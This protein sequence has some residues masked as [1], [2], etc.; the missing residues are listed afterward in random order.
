MKKGLSYWAF[1]NKTYREAFEYAKKNGFDGIEVT[2]N[3]S[4]EVTPETTDEEILEIK[5]QGLEAG[6]EFFSVA[7]GLLWDYPLTSNDPAV[8]EKAMNLVR[9]QL[10]IAQL[11]GCD[12]ILVVPA[13]VT[14]DVPYEV[15]HERAFEAVSE[16]IPY[17][18]KC[19]VV[20]GLENVWNKAFLS[21]LETRDFIDRFNSPWVK[22]YFDIGNV[23]YMG[24][25]EQ[26]IDI[27][28]ERICK[29]HVKDFVRKTFKG[30]DIGTGDCDYNKVIAALERC[31]YN[32]FCTAE[33]FP[34]GEE[35]YETADKAA[36]AMNRIFG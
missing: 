34:E 21:P 16:L 26:W 14:E 4:G 1:Y 17:A 19:G 22:M 23:M 33:V 6:L 24:Y 7:T 15:A 20:M 12:S 10:E 25:P 11:L 5:R 18:E 13:L 9:R 2:I 35:E 31:G 30:A 32:D 3:A 36:S 29:V 8:R 28:G 27:L